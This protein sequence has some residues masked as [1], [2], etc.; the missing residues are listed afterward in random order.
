[1]SNEAL[2]NALAELKARIEGIPKT[3]DRMKAADEAAEA[4]RTYESLLCAVRDDAIRTDRQLYPNRSITQLVL[5][6]GIGRA[7]IANARRVTRPVKYRY[8]DE[9]RL[10]EA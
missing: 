7:T 9:R 4:L 1:V 8:E 6:T 2:E 3:L 5:W 10:D